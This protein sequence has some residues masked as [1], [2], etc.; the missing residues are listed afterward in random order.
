MLPEPIAEIVAFME[1]LAAAEQSLTVTLFALDGCLR[2]GDTVFYPE[3][4]S[5]GVPE[6]AYCR[7][8]GTVNLVEIKPPY[9]YGW[10]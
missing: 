6:Q 1:R 2:C 5:D 4:V 7:R 10:K 8:C 3:W 9:R